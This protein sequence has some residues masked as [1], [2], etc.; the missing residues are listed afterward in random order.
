MIGSFSRCSMIPCLHFRRIHHGFSF[1][2]VLLQFS[3]HR[4]SL[5]SAS[6]LKYPDEDSNSRSFPS[7]TPL[8]NSKETPFVSSAVN[9]VTASNQCYGKE[10]DEVKSRNRMITDYIRSGDL[11][12]AYNVFENMPVRTTVTWNSMLAG[13]TKIAGRIEDARQLFDNIPEPDIVSY[14]TMLN[15]Y[16]HNCGI[17]SAQAFF[18]QM[19]FTDTASWNTMVSGF[20][21]NGMM[22]QA[23]QLF[24]VMP[25]KNN[26]SWNLMI[27]GYAGIG[28]LISAEKL[29]RN[30][31][32][33]CV[34]AWTAM[35]TGY[36]K[37]RKVD[38]AEK[39]FDEMPEKNLVTWNTMVSGYVENGRADDG[40]KLFRKMV[41]TGVKP[42]PSTLSSVLL[43]CSNLSSLK[44]GKQV[45]QFVNKSPLSLHTMVNT[46][47]VSMYC[48]CGDL[49]GAWKLFLAISHKDIVTWNAMISG[50]A[51]HG[52]SEKALWLFD[53]M[54]KK[55][56]RP[57]WITF[58]GVLSACNHAGLVD[59]GIQYFDS[60]QKDY[61]IK[62]KP[63]HFTCM[64]DLLGRA[65]KLLEA[66]D[67]IKSMP[68]KPHPAIF[69]TLLGACRVHKNLE[70]A[71][72]A[73]R[74]LLDCDPS[75]AAGYVQL[76]NV[77][78][79]MRKWDCVSKVRRLM[80][81]DKV[82]KFPGYSWIEVKS[83]VHEF[84]SADR[85]HPEL[86]L[87]HEKLNRLEKKMRLAGYVPVLEFALH[88]VGDQQK[89]KLLLWHSEKLAIA[90]GLLRMPAGV[91]IRVFKNLRVCGDCHEATK[92]IS[93]LEGREIIVRDNSRF[94]HF[95][96]GKCSCGDY[97]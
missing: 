6:E 30:A 9:R 39:V 42:N 85:L 95:Q 36:M 13:Y 55:G 68:F 44:L 80:K 21:Q 84:R 31:P 48:K 28:D 61:K 90:Y 1:L 33:Q 40:L 17:K 70:L 66:L 4:H 10:L 49:D 82:I 45:H 63:D 94:H 34:V 2:N 60:L 22:D 29:F 5:L 83:T 77:Y 54:K 46:S 67:L 52:A 11:D 71:E 96:N 24:Q 88:D 37:S 75:N 14:N 20:C 97:W 16:M 78:A 72:F 38:L 27:S 74:N 81:D 15:C 62:A 32:S 64:V 65:G 8:N 73:A 51:Q 91:P 58:I 69:G 18:D 53:T 56:M 59:L 19:V 43:G 26:V 41:E 50:Y 35:V 89:E 7:N 57:D 3:Y 23:Y 47:L 86:G 25:E 87:I 93:A 76:A 92:F 12:S 79:A